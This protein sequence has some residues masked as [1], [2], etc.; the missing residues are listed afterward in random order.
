MRKTWLL[1]GCCALWT[2]TWTWIGPDAARAD[3][4]PARPVR[5][6]ASAAPGGGVDIVARIF[7]QSLSEQLHQSFVVENQSGAGGT[8][9]TSYVAKAA[10]DGYTLLA[11]ANAELTLAPFIHDHLPYQP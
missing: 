2:W 5:I 10:P 7:A 8:I 4:W 6:I 9:A 1:I 11:C 3:D